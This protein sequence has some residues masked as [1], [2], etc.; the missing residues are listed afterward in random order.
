MMY[1]YILLSGLY[2]LSCGALILAI[3]WLMA[4]KNDSFSY[5][6]ILVAL[7][8]LPAI[9]VP[10]FYKNKTMSGS[11]LTAFALFASFLT[12]LFLFF[13]HNQILILSLNTILWLFF[14]IMESSWEAWFAALA[15]NYTKQ[16][17]LKFSS[18]SMSVNQASLML[19][20]II[21]A[22]IFKDNPQIVIL[23][24]SLLFLFVF[25][26]ALFYPT[27][28]N[29]FK[30]ESHINQKIKIS[31]LE[32]SLVLIW[33]TLAL[34]NF[35]LPVQIAFEKGDMTEVGILDVMMGLGMICSSFLLSKEVLHRLFIRYKLNIILLIF[36]ILLWGFWQDFIFKLFCVFILG[37]CFNVSRI[38][39]RSALA[40]KYEELLVGQLVSKAN[41]YSFFIII[42]TLFFVYDKMS[43]NYAMPFIFAIL[44][45]LLGLKR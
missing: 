34:F 8:F 35:M 40:Q 5:L 30:E 36:A 11:K 6:A 29:N 21:S 10:L 13:T 38:L 27:K 26:V 32:L 15:K 22:L 37:L 31:T 43:I 19:G 44:I 17:I 20:P 12:S 4:T 2:R 28:A 39:I 16:E 42:F 25:F 18:L 33:P 41:A 14:F 7:T 9:L 45:A 3:H 1:V 23:I 24:S